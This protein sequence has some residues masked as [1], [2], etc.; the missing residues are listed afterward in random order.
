[1]LLLNIYRRSFIFFYSLK[2]GEPSSLEEINSIALKTPYYKENGVEKNLNKENLRNNGLLFLRKYRF[3]VKKNTSGGSTGKP[4]AFYQDF[5]YRSIVRNEIF[6]RMRSLDWEPGESYFKLWG[7][8]KE[9]RGSKSKTRRFINWS[10]NLHEF[11]SFELNDDLF[12]NLHSFIER[13]KP[14]FGECYV[15]SLYHFAL[16]LDKLDKSVDVP[17]VIVTAGSLQQKQY[18]LIRKRISSRVVN[19]YGSR[20]VGNIAYSS[21]KNPFILFPTYYNLLEFKSYSGELK[22]ILVTSLANKCH[23]L[24]RYEISDLTSVRS[25]SEVLYNVS[26][27]TVDMFRSISGTLI[28]GEYF[29]HLLYSCESIIDFQFIQKSFE[30]IEFKYVGNLSDKE[31]KYIVEGCKEVMGD[32]D[33][34][35]IN[36]HRFA[37]TKRKFRYTLCEI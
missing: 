32:V 36:V 31:K 17:F 30:L 22:E 12:T 15:H 10:L 18:D 20:E 13:N 23:P 28:D 21:D 37:N 7:D 26:G 14:R 11:N 16:W 25:T 34:V 33:V 9:L 4:V 5:T 6:S 8:D 35:I 2:F 27:R 24:I 19:R 3:G 1:M 29:T